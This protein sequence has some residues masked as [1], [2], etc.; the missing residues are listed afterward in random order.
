MGGEPVWVLV[1]DVTGD[2]QEVVYD[3]AHLD[4]ADAFAKAEYGP[5]ILPTYMDGAAGPSPLRPWR[6]HRH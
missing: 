4:S 1:S 5:N 3:Q 2:S 6:K